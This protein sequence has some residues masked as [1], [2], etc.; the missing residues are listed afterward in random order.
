MLVPSLTAAVMFTKCR[1]NG[2]DFVIIL[3]IIL[4]YGAKLTDAKLDVVLVIY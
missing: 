1:N 3:K 2:I 4:Y